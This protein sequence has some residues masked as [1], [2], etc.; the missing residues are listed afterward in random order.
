VLANRSE[1]A[2]R[3]EIGDY[4]LKRVLSEAGIEIDEGRGSHLPLLVD[5]AMSVRG[6]FARARSR[7]AQ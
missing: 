3:V 7:V 6:A 2:P 4:S 5:G 1:R